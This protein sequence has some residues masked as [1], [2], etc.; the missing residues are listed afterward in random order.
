MS[1]YDYVI[2]G[3][4]P[5]S[6]AAA[7]EV[8]GVGK[9]VLIIDSSSV[10]SQAQIIYKSI[11]TIFKQNSN[12]RFFHDSYA[13]S[14]EDRDA[15]LVKTKFGHDVCRKSSSSHDASFYISNVK[16]G[17][18]EVWGSAI[19]PAHPEIT[20]KYPFAEELNKNQSSILN[21]LPK[22][23][24]SKSF[25][26]FAPDLQ[27]EPFENLIPSELQKR[28]PHE[29]LTPF[30][31]LPTPLSI[32]MEGESSCINCGKCMTGCPVGAIWSATEFM[33]EVKDFIEYLPNCLV[34]SFTENENEVIVTFIDLLRNVETS[35]STKA[36][37]IGAGVF[38]TAEIILNSGINKSAIFGR[39]STVVQGVHLTMPMKRSQRRKTLSEVTIIKYSKTIEHQ[40]C[41]IYRISD[42]AVE[43]LNLESRYLRFL[44]KIALPILEKF[45]VVSFTYFP[46]TESATFEIARQNEVIFESKSRWFTFLHYLKRIIA[47]APMLFKMKILPSPIFFIVKDKGQGMHFSSTFPFSETETSGNY[48]SAS[49]SPCNLKRVFLLDSSVL[50]EPILG[51]PTLF[52]MAN[53][54]RI[55]RSAVQLYG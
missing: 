21:K 15:S 7:Q 20:K 10:S 53:A 6:A 11:A 48:S 51:P 46:A 34:K 30:I 55:A 37:L 38:G 5:S 50:V 27:I 33:D 42:S 41:Q 54:A 8:I 44:T 35:V 43:A 49:G 14:I 23:G 36:L 19:L 47:V 45:F 52:T 29:D 26:L 28:I 2:V 31:V 18:S 39:D 22:Y 16:G 13:E 12:Y 32:A 17:F 3:S 1:L 9:R 25:A 4:G 24:S 40:Y